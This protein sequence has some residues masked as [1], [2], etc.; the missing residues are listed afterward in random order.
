MD[1][2]ASLAKEQLDTAEAAARAARMAAWAAVASAFGV[3]VQ[4]I[5]A[6]VRHQ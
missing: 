1:N 4:V 2:A 5:I 3:V 6:I